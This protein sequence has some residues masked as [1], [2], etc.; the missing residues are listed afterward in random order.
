MKP[1][2]E[3][4]EGRRGREGQ[5]ASG[6]PPAPEAVPDAP[7]EEGVEKI[8]G[9]NYFIATVTRPPKVYRGNPFQVEV[10]LAYG[11]SWPADKTIELFRFANRVP[12]LFQRGA[13][14][15][16]EAI[17]RTDWRNYL[18]SQ[19]KGSL[20]VGPMALLVHIASVWVPFTSE[21]KEAV[22]HYPDIIKEIQ[23]A[24]QECGR[25]LATFIRKRKAADY[26][27]QR[28]SIFEL[29]IEEVAAAIG[30][31][32]GRKPGPIKRE[33][34]QVAHKVTAA[35][36]KEEEKAMELE[37]REAKQKAKARTERGGVDGPAQ[38]RHLQEDGRQDREAGRGRA[39]DGGAA[40]RTPSS[41]SPCAPWPT[42]P[43]ARRRR[44]VELG[45][46]KQKRYFFNVVDGQEV[47]ADLP[48][49]RG[50]Q[51]AD[52]LRQ[53][54]QHPRP[55]LRH[56]AHHR[57]HARRTPSRSRTSPTPSSRTSRSR[58]TPCARS[59]TCSPR[60]RASMVGPITITDSGDTID[61][62]R[63]GSGGWAVPSIVEENVITF[64]KHE[65]K[66]V[67]L[68]EKDAVWTRFNEDKFWKR[69]N[70]IIVQGGGQPPRGVRRL[71]Q[72]LHSELKLPVYVLVDNDPWGFYIYSVMK[73]GSINLAYESMR[74]AVPDARF[75]GLSS[76][77]KDKYQLP[78][79][80]AIKMDDGDNNRAKQMLAYPWFKQAQ[81]AARDPGDG[82]ERP[83]VRAGGALPA[84]HQLH[85]RGVPAQEAEGPGLA[86]VACRLPERRTALVHRSRS[87][88]AWPSRR[89]RPGVAGARRPR[90]RPHRPRGQVDAR[91]GA[92]SRPPCRAYGIPG[93]TVG[94]GARA[95]SCAGRPG[96]GMADLENF[97]PAT[98]ADRVPAGLGHQAHHRHRRAAAGGAG[99]SSTS[100][101]RCSSYVPAFPEKPWPVTA[102]Q[103]LAHQA[104]IRNWTDEEFQQHAPLRVARGRRWPCSRTT[105]W[106]SSPAPRSSTRPTATTCWAAC[107]EGASGERFLD[108][109]RKNVFEPAGMESARADDVFA[110]IPNRA[111][112]YSGTATATCAT[113]PS[114]TRATASPAAGW[115]PPPTTWR[116]S[117]RP[118][119]AACC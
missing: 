107:V 49:E 82:E 52:R 115:S 18:L 100:T 33:F 32:T 85:H 94:R 87:P 91:R 109:L 56:Q 90:P 108:Y 40:A 55:L 78:D 46:Q 79:N 8:K 45:N 57:R 113:R 83:Q 15:I 21:S 51:G 98:R 3:G 38:G 106:P 20:P 34:L 59:C 65:A 75:V 114:P 119:S 28:R 93:L 104:G 27:A 77:D 4:G 80:V 23:L 105:R 48:G 7:P 26:Q 53:D 71:V 117:R 36:M 61:L 66:Y 101:R 6:A 68:I 50:L 12:L 30:K 19:P 11:G 44:L 25:K 74:M 102:R 103:L 17:V 118:C 60:A 29:Y 54:H 42:S 41:T 5:G 116:A 10:G 14:G 88:P 84:R 31:I 16:T 13:C 43:G 81:L 2:Q 1:A 112:G 89:R 37:A 86:G 22:A 95:A 62:R 99:A 64:R 111:R 58:W 24:A 92:R 63:M 35:E 76:F 96:Y 70:C 9:H 67:L 97:V 47:H 110:I 72:R 69:N 39:E 73:Q